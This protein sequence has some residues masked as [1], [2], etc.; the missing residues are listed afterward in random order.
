MLNA[1]TDFVEWHRP[2]WEGD[3]L[4]G[5]QRTG[6]HPQGHLWA[7]IE[8]KSKNISRNPQQETL[9]VTTREEPGVSLHDEILWQGRPFSVV[10]G[11][12]PLPTS[13][14]Y[15]TFLMRPPCNC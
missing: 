6:S 4:G 2:T 13:P 15:Q 7:R 14:L 9:T 12:V 10:Q 5:R 1:L 8:T 11:P 3:G